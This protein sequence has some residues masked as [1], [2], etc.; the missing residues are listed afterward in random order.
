M[1]ELEAAIY[2]TL[3]GAAPLVA[4]LASTTAVYYRLAPQTATYPLVVFDY[5]SE[6]TAD[7]APGH[8]GKDF[9]YQVVGIVGDRQ[10]T[11]AGVTMRAAGA[12]DA[13]IEPLLHRKLIAV[14]SWTN[15]WTVRESGIRMEEIA[16]GGKRFYHA[17]G[18]YRFRLNQ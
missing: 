2:T 3:T 1:N 12:I 18:T 8:R 16:P 6:V 5:V 14:A 11:G 17:G 4:L 9:L 15:F 7:M 10:G 13:Q